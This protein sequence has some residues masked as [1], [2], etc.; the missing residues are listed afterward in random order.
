M[1]S[2][3]FKRLFSTGPNSNFLVKEIPVLTKETAK[4]LREISDSS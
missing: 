1:Y 4:K 3:D 2:N